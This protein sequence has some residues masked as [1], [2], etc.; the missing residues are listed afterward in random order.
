MSG[1][2]GFPGSG[3]YGRHS[4]LVGVGV[5]VE[6]AHEIAI[7]DRVEQIVFFISYLPFINSTDVP[8]VT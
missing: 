7:A 3:T 1:P 2:Q 4:C 8:G 6:A 5:G